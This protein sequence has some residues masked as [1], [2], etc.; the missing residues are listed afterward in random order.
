MLI[1][2]QKHHVVG[3]NHRKLFLVSFVAKLVSGEILV[4]MCCCFCFLF[5]GQYPVESEAA[6]GFEKAI[7]VRMY[8]NHPILHVGILKAENGDASHPSHDN[9]LEGMVVVV[10]KHGEKKLPKKWVFLRIPVT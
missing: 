9:C 6:K 2:Q 5:L 8:E 3:W 10:D 4:L 1:F 7:P